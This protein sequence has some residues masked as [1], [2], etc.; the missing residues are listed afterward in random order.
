MSRSRYWVWFLVL[1]FVYLQYLL[2]FSP[3]GL[4]NSWHLEEL[5]SKQEQQ[6]TKLQECNTLLKNEILYL[7]KSRNALEERAR[8]E[9]DMIKPGEIYIQIEDSNKTA[10][11]N[12]EINKK[13]QFGQ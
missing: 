1:I 4:F 2:W 5:I 3:R 8:F 11:R 10:H 9:L 6:N 7:R 12:L 13:C